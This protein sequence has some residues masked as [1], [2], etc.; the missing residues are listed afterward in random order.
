MFLTEDSFFLCLFVKVFPAN[1][2][3]VNVTHIGNV[4]GIQSL[5]Y[6]LFAPLQKKN[7]PNPLP[8]EGLRQSKLNKHELYYILSEADGFYEEKY[9]GIENKR[10]VIVLTRWEWRPIRR[11]PLR[12]EWSEG[13]SWEDIHTKSIPGRGTDI[14]RPLFY[15][16]IHS[17]I[18]ESV[19]GCQFTEMCC[20]VLCPPKNS[21]L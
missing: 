6:L 8:V 3:F 16:G 2:P 13:L 5:K 10:G 19:C 20:L 12:F 9:S 18:Q 21:N 14:S 4:T 17:F 7:S 1:F 11:L 15:T